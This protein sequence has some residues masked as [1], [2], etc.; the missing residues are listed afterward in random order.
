VEQ[1]AAEV[2]A[3][4]EGRRALETRI[5][6]LEQERDRHL[7]SVEQAAAEV[8][9]S[10][11]G[12]RA[13]EGRIR[14]LEQERDRHLAAV[15]ELKATAAAQAEDLAARETES[16]NLADLEGLLE[17][18]TGVLHARVQELEAER[19]RLEAERDELQGRLAEAIAAPPAPEPA[20]PAVATTRAYD[21]SAHLLFVPS[22]AGYLLLE[23]TGAAPHAGETVEVEGAALVVTKVGP[24]PFGTSSFACAYLAET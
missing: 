4:A 24:S 6:D 3:S 18:V 14:E 12:R 23:R 21:E 17:N 13:L 5:R 15:D 9:A 11:E 20:A 16:G 7:A 10:A 1:A 19:A 22:S 8:R 2:R